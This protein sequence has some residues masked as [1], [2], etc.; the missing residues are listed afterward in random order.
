EILP[1]SN[2]RSVS[3]CLTHC[4]DS[5]YAIAYGKVVRTGWAADG[6]GNFVLVKHN[7]Y[8]VSLFSVYAHNDI[9]LVAEGDVVIAGTPIAEM[10]STVNTSVHL[11]F[12][13]RRATNV[14]LSQDHPF[15][16]QIY[17]PSSLQELRANFVD[18][19]PIF[20]YHNTFAQW[21]QQN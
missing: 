12:E 21:D 4:G 17:W 3:Q 19:G 6:F 20:G 9:V 18:L 13:I 10:G 2:W 11:H 1:N 16:G 14:D 15:A 7:V 8:G 5:I